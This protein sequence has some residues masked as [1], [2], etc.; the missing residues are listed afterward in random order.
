MVGPK[1]LIFHLDLLHEPPCTVGPNQGRHAYEGAWCKG[2]VGV[3]DV[4]GHYHSGA[5][6][7]WGDTR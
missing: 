7:Y 6:Y 1:K 5:L 3:G 4:G 2:E